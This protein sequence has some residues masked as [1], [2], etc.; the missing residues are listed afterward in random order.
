MVQGEVLDLNQ[1]AAAEKETHT[2]NGSGLSIRNLKAH[3]FNKATPTSTG[4]THLDKATPPNK[5]HSLRT[6]FLQTTTLGDRAQALGA[7]ELG[8]Q[9]SA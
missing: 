4:H 3:S 8:A 7:Q 9:A 2:D 6:I 5:C 1:Q